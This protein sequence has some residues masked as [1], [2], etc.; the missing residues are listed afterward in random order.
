MI[1]GLTACQSTVLTESHSLKNAGTRPVKL[2]I[3]YPGSQT[4][5]IQA[6]SCGEAAF[7]K[8]FASGP[9]IESPIYADGSDA[10]KMIAVAGCTVNATLSDVPFGSRTFTVQLFNANRQFLTG[11]EIQNTA[12]VGQSNQNIEISFAHLVS[13]Q[14]MKSLNSGTPEDQFTASRVDLSA[15]Q[16]FVDTLTGKGGTAPNYTFTTHP[17][18]INVS[19]IVA[20]LKANGGDVSQLDTNDPNYAQAHG[21]L[22]V[23]LN[24]VLIGQTVTLSLDDPTSNNQSATSSGLSS[25][26]SLP[27]GT[28]NLRLYGPGYL[29]QSI[30]VTI[31]AGQLQTL[32]ATILPPK[33]MI[34]NLNV[35]FDEVGDSVTITGTDFNPT[36]AN[37][38]VFFGGTEASITGSGV[39]SLTVT[40]PEAAGSQPVTVRVGAQSSDPSA[41][42]VVPTLTS[43]SVATG[44]AGANITL[45]GKGFDGNAATNNQVKF[46]ATVAAVTNAT[47]NSLTVTVPAA[48]AGAQNV[49]VQV[50]TQTSAASN[51]TLKPGLTS[52]G[53]TS[54]FNG[55]PALVRGQI[56]T[57]NGTSFDTTPANNIVH[58][59]GVS[60]AAVT[61]TA[62]QLTLV[63]PDNVD[64]PGDV[65]VH[66]VS[67]GQASGSLTATVPTVGV[68]LDG[69]FN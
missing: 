65:S 34:T 51:F 22:D 18:L 43:L 29:T 44:T 69:G 32:N 9:G 66:V 10:Q 35:A 7:A 13:G 5:G 60:L 31:A 42:A 45:T 61:A 3:V 19:Q 25:M 56:L 12:I 49:T 11:S 8:V 16:T 30:P 46:G 28:W 6:F 50:G 33:P 27:P 62:T 54:T 39:N 59:G 24:G 57:L 21:N 17:S 37:N 55:K 41:F 23:T 67:N 68:A 63:I 40:V 4:F 52:L 20:D 47:A 38:R 64:T 15:L 14:V 26:T 1:L 48:R 58:M 36:Q 53:T 2:S